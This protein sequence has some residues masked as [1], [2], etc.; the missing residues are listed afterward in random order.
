MRFM[1][2]ST[3]SAVLRVAIIIC[4]SVLLMAAVAVGA[5]QGTFTN[6]SLGSAHALGGFADLR[7]GMFQDHMPVYLNGEWE[8]YPNVFQVGDR[9]NEKLLEGKQPQLVSLPLRSI[10]QSSGP[11]TYRLLIQSEG[12]L[13]GYSIYLENY[14]EDF[15]VY[16]NGQR[17]QSV[18]GGPQEK[19]LYT[20]SDYLFR[21]DVPLQPGTTELIISAN[22]SPRQALLFQNAIIFGPAD[23]LVDYM[24]RVWRDDTFLIGVILLLV[25]VGLVFMLMRTRFDMLSSITLF[26]TFLAVRILLGYNI[27]TYFIHRIL[28]GLPTGN[29]DFVGMQYVAFFITGVFGCL[30]SQ[31]IFD[32]ER[33]LPSWPVRA[34]IGVCIVGGIFTLFFFRRLPQIC[35]GLLFGVLV[36]SFLIVTWHIICLF[37]AG[38]FRAYY[39]FQIAKTYYVGAVMAIDILFFRGESYNALVYA[40]VVFLLAHLMARLID[41]NAS[42]QEAEKLNHNLEQMIAER[43]CEL[44]NA[45]QRLSEL[46][47]RDPL[48]QAHNRLYFEGALERVLRDYE[49]DSVYL[50]MFDLDHFK[51][52]N[53]RFG[54][55]AGDEQ[56]RF[57]VHVVNDVLDK[58]G[59]LSRIGGEEFVILFHSMTRDDI[60][61]LLERIRRQLEQDAKS[62]EKR[63]TA[64]FGLVRHRPAYAPKDFLLAADKCLYAAKKLGRNCIVTG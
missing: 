58:R 56:L 8:Y 41:S 54:H 16:I 57:I 25:I 23:D 35:V 39:A 62:N 18:W 14:N 44:T 17:V 24:A 5:L 19:L 28:P 20:M 15:A 3:A 29:V 33:R 63:T 48:T 52:I 1:K 46:S 40:Y 45:N 59:M 55:G 50:C 47:V 38:R 64:S 12:T 6:T 61:G 36:G 32:S 30:L 51:R 53:D 4:L 27:A 26:D 11:A 2:T 7:G 21:F 22:S 9:F 31:S 10:S 49:S 34:Q 42:Y 43:T 37:R 13:T 60:M